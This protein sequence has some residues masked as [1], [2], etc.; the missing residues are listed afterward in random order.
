MWATAE[1]I[2]ELLSLLLSVVVNTA[3]SNPE[4]QPDQQYRYLCYADYTDAWDPQATRLVSKCFWRIE[5]DS[6]I[7]PNIFAL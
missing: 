7:S 3:E 4:L 1:Q 5:C 2:N 6:S